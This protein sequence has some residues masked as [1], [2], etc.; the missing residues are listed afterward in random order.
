MRTWLLAI[1]LSLIYV[2]A[3][4]VCGDVLKH[5]VIVKSIGD[6]RY[7]SGHIEWAVGI[8]ISVLYVWTR[9]LF[10]S[11]R[12]L[13]TNKGVAIISGSLLWPLYLA[14]VGSLLFML[15]IDWPRL[16]MLWRHPSSC[17]WIAVSSDPMN[18]LGKWLDESDFWQNHIDMWRSR[19]TLSWLYSAYPP[20]SSSDIA[21][22]LT[23]ILGITLIAPLMYLIRT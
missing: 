23:C 7:A 21:V 15:P 8:F 2:S 1:W 5:A 3:S 4:L 9:P 18:T 22:G 19:G 6:E 11:W 10:Y 20:R 17:L 12:K 16:A 14:L 13:S